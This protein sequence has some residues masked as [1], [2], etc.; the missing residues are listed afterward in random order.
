VPAPPRRPPSPPGAKRARH[1]RWVRIATVVMIVGVVAAMAYGAYLTLFVQA[2]PTVAEEKIADC[3]KLLAGIAS[4]ITSYAERK[5]R[6]P[7]ILPDLRADWEDPSPYDANPW[8]RWDK[9]IEY[10]VVDAD[11]REFRLRSYGPDKTPDTADDIVWPD[12]KTW[13]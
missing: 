10:R 2:K 4:R 1:Q 8:D 9:P 11:K 13:K 5:G 7:Q 6:M 3:K 12:G